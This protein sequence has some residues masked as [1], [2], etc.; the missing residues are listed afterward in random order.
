MKEKFKLHIDKI[1]YKEKP[2]NEEMKIIKVRLQGD[3]PPVEVSLLELLEKIQEGKPVSPAVMHGTKAKDFEEQQIFMV[4]IDNKKTDIPLL[5]VEKA[6]KICKKNHLQPVFY[7]YTFS[8]TEEIPKFRLVFMMDEVITD[9]VLRDTV[10]R[11][12]IDLFDQADTSCKNADR[13]FFGTNKEAI[14]CDLKARISLDTILKMDPIPIIEKTDKSYKYKTDR[15]LDKM[16]IDFDFLGYLKKRN[17]KIKRD[18]SIYAM[19]ENCEICGHHEDLVYY[20]ETNSFY[21]FSDDGDVGGTII[22]YLMATEDL[23]LKQ[24]IRKFKKEI[25]KMSKTSKKLKVIRMSD[26]KL[27][28]VK[29][30]WYPYIPAGKV[31]LTYGNPRRR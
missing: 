17:G 3:S 23:T 14:I 9:H 31:T 20:Y 26:V 30:L 19:F 25:Y 8:H 5:T 1:S 12:L 13:V 4:D 29:W 11:R 28:K 24:A 21:C 7:Y 15:E 2:T 10:I 16:K 22:D 6:L 18:T 27:K